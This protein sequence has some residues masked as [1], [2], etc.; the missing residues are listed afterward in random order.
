MDNKQS[1][2]RN[3]IRQFSLGTAAAISLPAIVS[4]AYA[5][6]QK[7]KK[8]SL[9]K[10]EIVLFQGDSITDAGR[11]KGDND[12]NSAVALGRGYACIAASQLLFDHAAKGLRIYNRGI[13]GNKVYQLAERWDADCLE[14]KPTTLSILVG[15][16]NFWHLLLGTYKGT[17]ETYRSDFDALL[18]RSKE[19][20]PGVK[21]IIGEPFALTGVSA[22]DA[23]WYPAFDEYRKVAR[24]LS[25]AHG[26]VFV[27]YQSVFDKALQQA[28]ASY[29]T[30]DGV[31]PTL[32]GAQLMA[33]AWLK[34]V[35]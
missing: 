22:V 13:S 7:V 15:V 9:E 32:A 17:I 33:E 28:P 30:T 1:S 20:L 27:P 23:K 29:W 31:H 6:E 5:G 21:L 25:N 12:V 14:L 10:N 8:L 19:N 18:K 3:F 2:R 35:K 4:S 11:K 26:A 34:A 16:N 24:E